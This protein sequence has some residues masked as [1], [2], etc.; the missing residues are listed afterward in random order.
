RGSQRH[1]GAP[2]GEAPHARRRRT[3]IPSCGLGAVRVVGRGS[4]R[5]DRA[6]ARS[7]LHAAGWR[8]FGLSRFSATIGGRGDDP[9]IAR[10]TATG[11]RLPMIPFLSLALAALLGADPELDVSTVLANVRAAIGYDRIVKASDGYVTEGTSNYLGRD[12]PYRFWFDGTG[13]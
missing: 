4:L 6:L 13:R 2:S 12:V 1:H 5:S 9:A 3:D 10:V 7:G 8:S 11:S